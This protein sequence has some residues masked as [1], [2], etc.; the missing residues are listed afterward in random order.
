MYNAWLAAQIIGFLFGMAGCY[1]LG[2]FHLIVGILFILFGNN[3]QHGVK[4]D[5]EYKPDVRDKSW[6]Q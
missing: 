3:L 6:E 1:I 2:D 4:K 5:G